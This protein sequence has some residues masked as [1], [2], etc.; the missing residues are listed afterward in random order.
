MRLFRFLLTAICCSVTVPTPAQ[1][2][3]A[4]Q[5]FDSAQI[6]KRV[7]PGV[8]LI[9]GATDAGEVLGT[10]FIISSDGKIAANLHV[11]EGLKNGGV[12]LASV[13]NSIRFPSWRSRPGNIIG[14]VVRQGKLLAGIGIVA[15]LVGAAALT[16]IMSSLLFGVNTTRSPSGQCLRCWR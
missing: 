15:G 2:Q 8:V 16:R 14:L 10:G 3:A 1:P 4:S 12:Q 5:P 13:T 11:I 6:T 7:A 9:K